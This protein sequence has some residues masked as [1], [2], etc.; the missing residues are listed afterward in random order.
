M[1]ALHAHRA[2]LLAT[3]VCVSGC[4]DGPQTTTLVTVTSDP[5]ESSS[6][7]A[8]GTDTT[9]TDDTTGA[10][11]GTA[12]SESNSE[13]G[14]TTDSSTSSVTTGTTA[15][16]VVCGDGEVQGDEEC[17][18]GNDNNL[19]ACLN[20]CELAGCG[21]GILHED[22]G[23]EC[24]DGN[25]DED[26]GCN[27]QCARDR[28]VFLTSTTTQGK[29]GAVSGANSHCKSL[30]QDAGLPNPLTYRAWMSDDTF[31]PDE[32]FFKSKGR[33]LLTNGAVVAKDWE[34]LTDGTLEN[35][36]NVDENGE[37]GNGGAWTNTTPQGLK[38]PDPADCDG[39]TVTAF[40]TEGRIGL[41]SRTDGEWSDAENFNPE[42]CGANAHF[43][44]FEN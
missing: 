19:D 21:D 37:L 5:D 11:A 40:P 27:S 17:D 42:D 29:F 44:C 7:G 3:V 28:I 39:W 8:T 14:A 18:D 32:W 33:Y 16:E 15:G 26:D 9:T 25:S 10:T 36:I 13:S 24:D 23:E 43:Y 6:S 38:H 35:A 12:G 34:D 1:P 41:V 4:P 31:S 30:A 22:F 2:F 20:S